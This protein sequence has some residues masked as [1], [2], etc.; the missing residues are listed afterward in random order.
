[1]SSTPSG[2]R[3]KFFDTCHSK[4]WKEYFYPSTV[5]PMW[6]EDLENMFREQLTELAFIHE[7][8]AEFGEQA[9]GV[10][11][12]SYVEAAQRPYKYGDFAR[13]PDWIYTMGVDWNDVQNGTTIAVFG[14]NPY[15][16]RFTIVDK[17]V[18][19]REGWN[20]LEACQ[21]VAEMNRLWRPKSIYLDAGYGGTQFEVLKKYGW[22]ATHDKARGPNHPDAQLRY[23]L[24]QYEFGS[25]VEVR[26]LWTGQPVNRPAKPFLVENLVR[27]FESGDIV[28]PE[29]D[30]VFTKQLLGYI[31]ERVTPTGTPVFGAS[32]EKVGDHF[33][34]AVML[35]AVA[36]TLEQT[37]FGKRIQSAAIAFSGKLGEKT[38]A[39]ISPGDLVIKPDPGK[40][41]AQRDKNKPSMN[42]TETSPVESILNPGAGLPA[43]NTANSS[44]SGSI[45][46]W[47]W[48]GFGHDKPRP[49]VRRIGRKKGQKRPSRKN[50]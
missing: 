13:D 44:I 29:S 12:N 37:P 49:T 23:T 42:R 14:Y 5:N 9:Q 19:S 33:L 8:E 34:D 4:L 39:L 15:Q 35:A 45:G 6:N 24:K 7:I 3:E 28:Y 17:A 11:Q 47:N 31:I 26:D 2:K 50:I 48:P 18:I 38:D 22:D 43:N 1:M 27:R 30:E 32:D 21:K 41:G 40:R 10:F 16:S 36:F 25:K 46:L 20:Q